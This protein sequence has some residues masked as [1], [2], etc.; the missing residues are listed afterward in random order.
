MAN[1]SSVTI[2]SNCTVNARLTDGRNYTGT[3]SITESRIDKTAPTISS[4]TAGTVTTSTIPVTVSASDS[5]GSGISNYKFYLGSELKATQT[6]S[7]YT[8]ED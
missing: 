6:T 4:F 3:A 8:Y 1:T 7:S 5:G 2:S